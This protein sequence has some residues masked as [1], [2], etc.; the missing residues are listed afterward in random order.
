MRN[1]TFS[2]AGGCQNAVGNHPRSAAPRA[3]RRDRPISASSPRR[4]AL[5]TPLVLGVLPLTAPA[6]AAD[7]EEDDE[8][9]SSSS[10][11]KKVGTVGLALVAADAVSAAV[12]GKSLLAISQK[13]KEGDGGVAKG[14]G[15][16]GWKEI[17]AERV[18]ENM[19]SSSSDPSRKDDDDDDADRPGASSAAASA[20]A[21]AEDVGRGGGGGR[22]QK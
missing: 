18:I 6:A 10:P 3:T 2:V 19:A 4:A 21:P 5:L 20:D 13:V 8:S 14:E 11:L 1:S 22:G 15:G 9:S 7:A 16:G 17:L 12:L